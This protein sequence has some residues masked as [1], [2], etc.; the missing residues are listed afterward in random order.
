MSEQPPSPRPRRP[1]P[2]SRREV[3]QY[4]ESLTPPRPEVVLQMEENAREQH[5]P[6]IGAACGH[7]CYLLTRMTG[8]RHVF[9]LGSGYGYSTYW[10]A[11]AVRDNGGGC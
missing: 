6:I 10:F 3:D 4:V 1:E 9:E 5:F 8:A 7:L 2:P 11:R